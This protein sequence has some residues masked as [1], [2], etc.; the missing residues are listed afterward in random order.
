MVTLSESAEGPSVE[1]FHRKH[2]RHEMEGCR[3]L[4]SRQ[5]G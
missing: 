1:G 2:P 4:K 3:H 5:L